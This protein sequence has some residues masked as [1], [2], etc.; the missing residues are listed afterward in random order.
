MSASKNSKHIKNG[1][2]LI[3]DKIAQEE[4]EVQH[5]GTDEMWADMNTKPLQGMKFQVMRAQVMGIAVEYDDNMERRRTHPPLMPKVEPTSLSWDDTE[6]LKKVEI[7]VP[8]V[9]FKKGTK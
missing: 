4:L 9:S 6:V 1:F 7:I 5:K 2:F 3:T 8:G